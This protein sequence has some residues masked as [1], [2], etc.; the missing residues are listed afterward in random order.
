MIAVLAGIYAMLGDADD[1]MPLLEHL[2][3]G[4]VGISVHRLETPDWDGIRDDPR[5]QALLR[6]YGLKI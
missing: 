2:L 1:A 6:K 4:Q 5:F 3:R